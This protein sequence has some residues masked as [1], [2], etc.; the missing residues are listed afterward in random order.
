M[1]EVI[2][3]RSSYEYGELKSKVHALMQRLQGQRGS[4][5][6]G[7]RVLIKPNLLTAA[8]PELAITTHP[9]IVRAVAEYALDLGAKVQ[10]S[11]SSAVG[12]FSKVIAETGIAD[13]LKGMPVTM[14]P[15]DNS[16]E[17]KTGH[18]RFGTI[19]LSSDVLEADVIVNLPKLKTHCQ[20]GLTLAV[21]N[22]FGCV[23]GMRKPEW[24]FR[25][26]ENKELFAELL[27]VIYGSIKPAFNI[28]DGI[29][30]MEGQG[31]GT[32]GTPRHLGMLIGSSDA[33]SM[34]VAICRMLGLE[35]SY[36]LTTA[37]AR[38]AG[39]LE[40][41]T[42]IGDPLAV[43]NFKAPVIADLVFG[44]K[45]IRQFFRHH[46]TSHPKCIDDTCKL[47]N[48][49]LNI[50]PANAI[51]S[52]KKRLS[53]DYEKC[54]RCYCCLEV[55]PHKSIRKNDTAIKKVLEALLNAYTR[56]SR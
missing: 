9:L 39:L 43:A 19:E 47:C 18:H 33:P 38:R 6:P 52:D 56:L 54:I 17:L 14:K 22:L 1:P 42:V 7:S 40:M 30:A 20:M 31:P 24:H 12:V 46:T 15:L 21:K 53:F 41:P 26:G 34:D 49:C 3:Q 50:C 16:V 23:V 27:V 8:K 2:F 51:T 45:P 35:D 37:A 29:L 28:M 55:C 5:G 36:L 10:V 4:I 44:W 48:E 25:V 13:A 32:G 11:D